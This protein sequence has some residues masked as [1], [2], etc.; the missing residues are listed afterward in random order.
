V[1]LI[2]TSID[3]R[4]VVQLALGVAAGVVAG[5]GTLAVAVTSF[6]L[7]FD[8]LTAVAKAA[9]IRHEIAWMLAVAV[10]GAMLVATVS[11][12]VMGRMGRT[13][14]E[15]WY[16]WT[17]VI[18]GVLISIA[19][20]AVHAVGDLGP[21][22]EILLKLNDWQRAAIS[23]IPA[24]MLAASVHLLATLIDAFHALAG[25]GRRVDRID[26]IDPSPPIDAI[27]SSDPIEAVRVD[28]APD[29]SP[30]DPLD[31]TRQID[32]DPAP[33]GPTLD[34]RPVQGKSPRS[35]AAPKPASGTPFRSI[36]DLRNE[37]RAAIASGRID[38][39]PSAEAIRTALSCAPKRA[40]LLRDELQRSADPIESTGTEGEG[41]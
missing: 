29:R 36:S 19:C 37:L 25:S 40:R 6:S 28:P 9:H 38:P 8:A 26:S 18:A 41:D 32:P 17:V 33:I 22:G 27:G 16:P 1:K 23:A 35:I 24:V 21:R 7:S 10:D 3:W 11:A 5:V 13:G 4:A 39:Q 34:P 20:N 14:K 15:L 12:L 31:S 30:V 2:R